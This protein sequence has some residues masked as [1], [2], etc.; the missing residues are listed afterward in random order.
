MFVAC[1]IWCLA[2]VSSASPSTEQ[3]VDQPHIQ[4]IRPHSKTV[5]SKLVF[6]SLKFYCRVT[7]DHSPVKLSFTQSLKLTLFTCNIM[8][9]AKRQR[10]F[11][12]CSAQPASYI[13]L[14]KGNAAV[15]E[16]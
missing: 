11:F 3:T 15:I 8:G 1:G 6:Q 9:V 14:Q 16:D 12:M 10:F 2:D 5:F 13:S 4:C 7:A